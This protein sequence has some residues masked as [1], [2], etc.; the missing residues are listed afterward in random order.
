M[1]VAT[2]QHIR[3]ALRQHQDGMTLLEVMI[4]VAIMG[5]GLLGLGILQAKSI[6]QG[7]SSYF[8]GIAAD[9]GNDLADRIRAVRTPFM[10]ST[11]ATA[12]PGKPPDF[13]KCTQSGATVACA[14]QEA[15]RNTYQT[16]V[17]T[18]MQTWLDALRAQLP[19][20]T[21]TLVRATSASDDY[22]RY[23]L[24]I[25]WLDDRTNGS[26]TSYSVVIE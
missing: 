22:F 9:L 6:A 23:T 4:A 20:A 3:R 1:R 11:D 8:R 5:F 16:L 2:R 19:N 13:S 21:Y 26:N 18:E 14:N 7:Q 24:T 10:V 12:K 15:D 25:T 17:G